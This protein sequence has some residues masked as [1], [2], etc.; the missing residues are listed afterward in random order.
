MFQDLLSRRRSHRTFTPEDISQDDVQLLLRAALLSPSSRGRRT[1][2]FIV[3]D[4][5]LDLEKLADAKSGG[6]SFLKGCR[7]AVAVCG[8]AMDND[9]WIED[10]SIA[11]YGMLLQAE[12]LGLGGCWCQIHKR[13]LDDG[14]SAEDVVR[15]VLDIPDSQN[16][17]CIVGL[18]HKAAEGE[19]HDEDALKWENV[20]IDKFLQI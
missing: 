20:H 15:G 16:V 7:M 9:C 1:W 6:S 13:Y 5:A 18:G 4:N 17:L 8:D 14:T 11:A 3:V 19:P 12:E 10:G 2:H